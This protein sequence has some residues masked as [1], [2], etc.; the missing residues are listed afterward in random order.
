METLKA[1]THMNFGSSNVANSWRKWEQQFR[2][3]FQAAEVEKKSRQT[4]IAILLNVAGPEALETFNTFALD[5]QSED[6]TLDGVLTRFRSYCQ[7]RRNVVYERYRFWAR[8]QLNGETVDQWVTDLRT[9]AAT[10]EFGDQRDMIIRDKIV[11][12]T[13]DERT[14]ERLLREAD[15][16]LQKA[17]DTCRA[18]E[19]SR[20]Q[21][22]EMSKEPTAQTAI[23]VDAMDS[24]ASSRKQPPKKPDTRQ[25]P[26]SQGQCKYCGSNHPPRKCPAY[27]KTCPRC[28]KK[29]HFARVC[30]GERTQ[31]KPVQAIE[32]E[33]EES[34]EPLRV[35]DFH[36]RNG[37]LFRMDRRDNDQRHINKVQA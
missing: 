31:V 1:P 33:Y 25:Q 9:R 12:G 6:V 24:Q 32:E 36:W 20:F 37:R 28:H 19:A 30:R 14:K 29:N 11:F 21:I 22:Q 4:Q 7:P 2:I 35:P 34:D 17:L 23:Q 5:M 15:L 27:G 3:Y 8:N 16:T 10:C 13:S 18:A 26:Q